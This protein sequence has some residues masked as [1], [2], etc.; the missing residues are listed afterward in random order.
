MV[1]DLSLKGQSHLR[2]CMGVAD[3]WRLNQKLLRLC[4]EV[5]LSRETNKDVK[6]QKWPTVNAVSL[7]PPAPSYSEIQILNH[8]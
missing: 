5:D 1:T 6:T 2:E 4:G 8:F 3:Y 7:A